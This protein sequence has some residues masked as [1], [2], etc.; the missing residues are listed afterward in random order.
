MFHPYKSSALLCIPELCREI[1]GGSSA[2]ISESSSSGGNLRSYS[3]DA[4]SCHARAEMSVALKDY[5]LPITYTPRSRVDSSRGTS[6]PCSIGFA[7]LVQTF[8]RGPT[9]DPFP[10]ISHHNSRIPPTPL[11]TLPTGGPDELVLRVL[12]HIGQRDLLTDSIII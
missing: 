10:Q 5:G 2:A 4:K 1:L 8:L 11:L 12:D 7:G 6:C 3:L 9:C